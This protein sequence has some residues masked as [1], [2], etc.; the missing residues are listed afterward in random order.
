MYKTL[1]PVIAHLQPVVIV[2]DIAALGALDAA[3]Q[4]TVPLVGKNHTSLLNTL[5]ILNMR[6][7]TIGKH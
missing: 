6:V 4:S 3:A 2:A 1:M 5:Y 7:P